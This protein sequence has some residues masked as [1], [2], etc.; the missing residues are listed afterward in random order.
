MELKHSWAAGIIDGE[1]TICIE[2]NAKRGNAARIVI[3]VSNTDLRILDELKVLYGGNIY[4]NKRKD[5]PRSK[6]C[7]QWKITGKNTLSVISKLY[8]YLISKKEN[9]EKALTF[10]NQGLAFLLP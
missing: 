4:F 6:P 1:G 2:H 5:R 3:A 10:Y 8:P 9:A 7:W